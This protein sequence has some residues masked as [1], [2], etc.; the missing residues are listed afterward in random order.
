M[1]TLRLH[2]IQDIRLHNESK[3]E[4]GPGEVLVQV[5]SVGICGSDL[6]WFAEQGIGD[7]RLER[8]LV[9]GHEFAGIIASGP[10]VGERVAVDPAIACGQCE[11]CETGNPNFCENMRFAGHGSIDGAMREFISWPEKFLFPIPE[12]ISNED[13]AMLEPLGVAL[14]AV[15]LAEI[16]YGMKVGVF[17]CGLIGLLAIQLAQQSGVSQAFATEK[18]PHRLQM[19]QKFGATVFNADDSEADQIVTATKAH[20]LD[21]AIELAGDQAAVDAAITAVR[22]GGRVILGGIP[23]EDKTSFVASVARRKGLT[24]QLVRRMK[25]TY[26][27]AIEMVSSGKVDVRSVVTHRFSPEQASAAFLLAQAREGAKVVIN[28]A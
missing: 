12:N 21:V 20:G 14:Y 5:T 2:G 1:K 26:P 28:F 4:P 7:A 22:P 17:G 3:P 11:F 25:H 13:G 23:S 24:L 16:R 19:A 18:L 27:R 15:D 8:P 10:R 9:L 6:H